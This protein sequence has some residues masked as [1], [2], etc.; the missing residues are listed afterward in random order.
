MI[1]LHSSVTACPMLSSL[2]LFG[3]STNEED[4]KKNQT[5]T[6]GYAKKIHPTE[7][8]KLLKITKAAGDTTIN[9]RITTRGTKFS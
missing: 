4:L 9:P 1:S 2:I 5:L 3:S 8:K 7:I 6:I